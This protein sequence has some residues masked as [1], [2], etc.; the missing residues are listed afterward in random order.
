MSLLAN[1]LA[2]GRDC[3]FLFVH[4]KVCCANVADAAM[5][6]AIFFT[7]LK[8][9]KVYRVAVAYAIVA[10]LLIQATSILFP[11]FEAPSWVMKVFVTAEILG[12]PV[13]V[14]LAWGFQLNPE[15]P[16]RAEEVQTQE[17]KT[18][19][20]GLK[21]TAIIVAAAVIAAALLAFQFTRTRNSVT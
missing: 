19:K 4:K 18:G 15:G 5:D 2:P 3:K 1:V 10:W 6:P 20:T 8:R 17:T 13:A 14:I 12:F 21:R 7:E 11:T 9:R 16:R